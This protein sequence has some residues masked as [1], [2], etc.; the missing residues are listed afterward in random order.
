MGGSLDGAEI[1]PRTWNIPNIPEHRI[2]ITVM[3]KILK[4]KLN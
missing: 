1:K 4:I 2:S 3:R